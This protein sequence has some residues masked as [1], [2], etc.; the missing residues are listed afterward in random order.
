MILSRYKDYHR[1]S[2]LSQ[3][4][5]IKLK[6]SGVADRDDRRAVLN[7]L[8][9]AGYLAKRSLAEDSSK[10]QG[11]KRKLAEVGPS[12]TSITTVEAIVRHKLV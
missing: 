7:A 12:T 1:L 4:T 9:N 5:D 2:T 11:S 3:L 10:A 6:A 8:R